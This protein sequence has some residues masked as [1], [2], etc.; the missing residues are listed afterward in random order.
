MRGTPSGKQESAPWF[1]DRTA[2]LTRCLDPLSNDDL[3]VRQ[4]FLVRRAIGRAAREF[5]YLGNERLILLAPMQ[6][7]LVL[8]VDLH[9]PLLSALVSR[10]FGLR[11]HGSFRTGL[12]GGP[13]IVWLARKPMGDDDA[14]NLLDLVSL[15][16]AASGL[17]IEDLGHVVAGKDVVA[18]ADALDETEIHQ[19]CTQILETNVRV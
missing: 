11:T 18:A 1:G 17:E 12:L 16:F 10:T 19:Q 13:L 3:N 5:G 7:D 9:V 6:N 14:T 4:G 15:G 8:N 2:E